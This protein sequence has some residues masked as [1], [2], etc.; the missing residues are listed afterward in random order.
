MTFKKI[1]GI[2][3]IVIVLIFGFQNFGT[4]TLKFLFWNLELPGIAMIFLIF[5]VGFIAGFLFKAFK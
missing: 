1:S 2:I 3:L 5:I 4:S